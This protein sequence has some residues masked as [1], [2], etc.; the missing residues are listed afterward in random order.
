MDDVNNTVENGPAETAGD[1]KFNYGFV[2]LFNWNEEIQRPF[3]LFPRK[4]FSPNEIRDRCYEKLLIP[5]Q[6]IRKLM[7][8]KPLPGQK[9]SFFAKVEACKWTALIIYYIYCFY[10]YKITYIL[11]YRLR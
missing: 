3:K 9:L 2:I 4:A 11:Y 10:F 6:R 1:R 5:E 8:L 7:P